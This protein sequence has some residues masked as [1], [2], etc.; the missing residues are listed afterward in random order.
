MADTF[1]PQAFLGTS[2]ASSAAP[3]QSPG[4]A[5]A[6]PVGFDPKKFI[7]DGQATDKLTG[8][9]IPLPL[10]GNS[11]ETAMNKSPLSATDRMNLSF[12]NVPG[13]INYLKKR[14]QDAKQVTDDKGKLTPDLAVL[15]G[16]TWYR[17]NPV[18][19]D[20][21]DPWERT[22]EYM[23]DA[24]TYAP[25]ALGVGVALGTDFVSGGASTPATAAIA[26]ATAAGVRT[27]LGRIIG[28]YDATPAEQAWDVGFESLLNAGGSKI[29]A[30]VKPSAKY[31][32]DKLPAIAEAFKDT[33]EP[34]IPN[35]AK[36]ASSAIV[37]AASAGASSAKGLLKKALVGYSVGEPNF[38][39]MVENTDR[40][41]GLMKNLNDMSG[42]DVA[43]YH[44]EALRSQ[45]G[46]VQKIADN[47]RSTLTSIYGQ[48][49][50][51]ILANV[52]E[53]FSTNLEDPVYSAYSKAI[54][55]GLGVLQVGGK[56]LSGT[57]ALEHI[58]EKGMKN[59][60]FRMY[61]QDELTSAIARGAP[62]DKGVGSLATDKE[63]HGLL[64]DFYKNLGKFTGGADRSGVE[65]ARSLMDF[66]KVAG[67]LSQQMA[68]TEVGQSNPQIR[69]L[70]NEAKSSMDNSVY[71]ELKK[72][73]MGDKFLEMNKTYDNLSDKFK[74]LLQAK[75]QADGAV[76]PKAYEGLLNTFLSRP[77]KNA[78]ARFAIDDAI[79]AADAHGLKALSQKLI[80]DKLGI[81][82]A[83]A[84]K[85]FNPLSTSSFKAA[86]LNTSQVGMAAYLLTHP[87]PG[88]IAAA[89][90]VKAVTSPGVTSTGIAAVQGLTKGQQML[91]SLTKNQL[92][93]F[94]SS[95]QAMTAFTTGMVQAPLVRAQAEQQITQSIQQQMQ[96]Q[97]Q[98][99]QQQQQMIQQQQEAAK[100]K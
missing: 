71:Q 29:L 47:T 70:I 4:T 53:N 95:P 19:G 65:G 24:A 83:E 90:G 48:M 72:H 5:P 67:D 38:D 18:N 46:V 81:Q 8:E 73:G 28:T 50:N 20:I 79:Q 96:A 63:A 3:I 82:V 80:D 84:A 6:A 75:K 40:V 21:Q 88:M 85:A 13:N 59:S 58:A 11:P 76:G 69:M 7:N 22:K 39:T 12:G 16:G 94:L 78:S 97:Q 55:N 35:A 56:E 10:S 33:V 23:K 36:S 66:K 41:R 31:I 60:G 45:L 37:D 43:K 15:D 51:K 62:L 77:G 98:K 89:L 17:V 30:G 44:D 9:K 26:G 34:W 14:Y 99:V 91:S 49:R 27:S 86:A 64:Q 54:Q 93:N 52:P 42:G 57:A 68:D 100:T 92:D 1:D 74:P 61:S 32:A 2:S 87:N 25:E